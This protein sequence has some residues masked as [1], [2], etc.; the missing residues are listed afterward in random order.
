M[1]VGTKFENE[2]DKRSRQES[3]LKKINTLEMNR[4]LQNM[5]HNLKTRV[6]IPKLRLVLGSLL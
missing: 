1:I 2:I 3:S 5:E 4:K 6:H